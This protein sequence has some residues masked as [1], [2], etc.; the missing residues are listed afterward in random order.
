M[1]AAE[2]QHERLQQAPPITSM[3]MDQMLRHVQESDA[4]TYAMEAPTTTTEE[5]VSERERG[6]DARPRGALLVLQ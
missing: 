2:A 4:R 6:R 3:S 5:D 1:A